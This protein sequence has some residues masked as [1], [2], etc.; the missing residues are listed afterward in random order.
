M[1]N[2]GKCRHHNVFMNYESEFPWDD[3]LNFDLEFY[4]DFL[5]ERLRV[6]PKH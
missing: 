1:K 4:L 6:E 5:Q 3:T 2:T